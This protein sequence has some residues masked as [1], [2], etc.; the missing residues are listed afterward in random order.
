MQLL[1]QNYLLTHFQEYLLT[2]RYMYLHLQSRHIRRRNIGREEQTISS[3]YKE[4]SKWKLLTR[5][6]P[7]SLRTMLMSA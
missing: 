1:H 7:L 6:I 4:A 3:H 2:A 5:Q